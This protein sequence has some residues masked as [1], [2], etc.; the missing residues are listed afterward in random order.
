MKIDRFTVIQTWNTKKFHKNIT[1][2]RDEMQT[3]NTE[4]KFIIFD[5]EEMN[6]SIEEYF[7]KDIVSSYFK[8]KHFTPRADLWR[9]LMVYK[10]GCVYLDIDSLII[11]NISKLVK[12]NRTIL[13]MEPNKLNF[14]TWILIHKKNDKILSTASEMIID[15]IKSNKF[16]HDVMNL[17]GPSLYSKAIREV[18]KLQPFPEKINILN[19]ETRYL[20]Q[21]KEYDY[22]DNEDHDRFFKFTHQ[23]NH[24]LRKRRKSIFKIYKN[25][26]NHWQNFQKKN[27]LY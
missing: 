8:L 9:Y 22:L 2:L 6:N 16:K 20:F 17:S 21:Q 12:R 27:T 26:M 7:D 25:D 4:F 23:Y 1:N 19:Q 13:T 14:I 18:I 3:N 15:N 5:D 11:Q 10:Y 24:L